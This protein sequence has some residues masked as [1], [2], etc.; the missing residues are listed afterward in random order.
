MASTTPWIAEREPG[1]DDAV[2]W[3]LRA[4][5]TWIAT[6]YDGKGRDGEANAKLAALAHA[7]LHAGNGF[8]MAQRAIA[9]VLGMGAGVVIA[10]VVL[11]V[12]GAL[13]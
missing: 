3:G 9:A 5:G 2:A 10:I 1:V 6:F 11:K 7:A 4:N 8:L 12:S 13:L